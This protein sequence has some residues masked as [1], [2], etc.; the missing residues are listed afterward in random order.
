MDGSIGTPGA[1]NASQASFTPVI[2]RSDT[3]G[4]SIASD[5]SSRLGIHDNV[6]SD[7]H[8][9][10]PTVIP[11]LRTRTP[12]INNLNFPG[13]GTR[14]HATT[15]AAQNEIYKLERQLEKVFQNYTSSHGAYASFIS[16]ETVLLDKSHT[17]TAP[18]T[19]RLLH[20]RRQGTG[21]LHGPGSNNIPA[22]SLVMDSKQASLMLLNN[23]AEIIK[24]HPGATRL[25]MMHDVLGALEAPFLEWPVEGNISDDMISRKAGGLATNNITTLLVSQCNQ[26]LEIFEYINSSFRERDQMVRRVSEGGTKEFIAN[27]DVSRK[28]FNYCSG[29]ADNFVFLISN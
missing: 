23:I 24:K 16:Q 2:Q 9:P 28:I 7:R 13:P 19:N 25:P 29:V 10:Q 8:R 22:Q 26:A 6:P 5:H 20:P 17:A 15:T 1:H 18:L 12:K 14:I 21:H 11:P 27:R 3:A 4:L